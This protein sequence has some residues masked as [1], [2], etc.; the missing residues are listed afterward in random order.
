[1]QVLTKA[2]GD[3]YKIIFRI[4][5]EDQERRLLTGARSEDPKQTPPL[6]QDQDISQRVE[7]LKSLINMKEQENAKVLEQMHADLGEADPEEVDE[8]T[9]H[10]KSIRLET[11][12]AQKELNSLKQS[13][14]GA[15]SFLYSDKFPYQ[16]NEDRGVTRRGTFLRAGDDMEISE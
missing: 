5:R 7:S 10:L 11:E 1:M 3:N 13:D 6:Q 16:I 14:T 15:S 4:G 12:K 9:I 2:Y 8:F